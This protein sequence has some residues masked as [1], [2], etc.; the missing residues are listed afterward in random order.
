MN[1]QPI[2]REE[3]YLNNICNALQGE[4]IEPLDVPVTY[5][6]LF[7]QGIADA[8]EGT[9]DEY[10]KPLVR[11]H[12]F[13]NNIIASIVGDEPTDVEPLTREELYLKAIADKFG[14][15][16]T[17]L[18]EPLTRTEIYY[19]EIY[20]LA[21]GSSGEETTVTGYPLTLQDAVASPIVDYKVYGNSRQY[22]LP[23]G[24]EGLEY[25]ES[26]GTQYIDTLVTINTTDRIKVYLDYEYLGTADGTL[27]AQGACNV[28]FAYSGGYMTLNSA[29]Y[30]YDVS[31]RNMYY[32]MSNYN[33]YRQAEYEGVIYTGSQAVTKNSKF[34]LFGLGNDTDSPASIH[35]ARLYRCQIWRN[36]VLVRDF[37]PARKIDSNKG[38][39]LE[40]NTGRFYQNQG[41]GNFTLSRGKF[42]SYRYPVPIEYTGTLAESGEQ[43]GKYAIPIVISDGV[44]ETTTDIYLTEPLRKIYEFADYIDFANGKVVRV[45]GKT[46]LGDY[47]YNYTHAS[48]LDIYNTSTDVADMAKLAQSS[49]V[50]IWACDS[51]VPILRTEGAYN[52]TMR[53]SSSN[54][55]RTQ[56][57]MTNNDF[58]DPA[59]FK[60][61][62]SGVY[63]YYKLATPTEE[64]ITLPTLATYSGDNEVTVDTALAP[65][66]M[67]VT[68]MKKE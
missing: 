34:L 16:E 7:L 62:M 37:V 2:T 19:A 25:I 22:I 21:E 41:S 1:I 38:G 15:E 29:T 17:E 5:S 27:G 4:E 45:I 12:V 67:S 9:F 54:L 56:V 51:Y 55:N 65:S 3:L 30:V 44:N 42:P 52:N 24:Y 61:A 60:Q 33:Q 46:D 11:V 57:S 8:I 47:D 26:T 23:E 68:Y 50:P 32:I 28:S 43:A 39:L 40:K 64:T 31:G 59:D 66:D 6:E 18:P 13:Y 35:S 10:Q 14:G 36:D 20:E 63:L 53:Y 48:S 49:D 58:T